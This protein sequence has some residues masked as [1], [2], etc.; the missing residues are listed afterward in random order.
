MKQQVAA[1]EAPDL[2]HVRFRLKKPWPDFVTFYASGERRRLD[3]AEKVRR[4]GGRRRLREA[5]DWRRTLRSLFAPGGRAGAGSLRGA[6]RR[7]APSVKRVVMKVIPDKSTRLAA[8]EKWR[9]RHRLFDRRRTR[10]KNCRRTPGLTLKSVVLQGAILALLHRAVGPEIAVARCAGASG[11][12]PR[13]GPRGD[14]Q[15]ALPSGTAKSPTASSPTPSNIIRSRHRR[16]RSGRR[17]RS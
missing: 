17:R 5:P 10:A 14:E 7:K 15:G 6:L 9:G 2:Q 3:R 4:K 13:A 16:V 12:Q 8:L 11:R 1:I